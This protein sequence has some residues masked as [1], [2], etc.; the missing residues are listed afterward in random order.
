MEVEGLERI[1]TINH[2]NY[3]EEQLAEKELCLKQLAIIYPNVNRYYAELVYDMCKNTSDEQMEILKKK[4]LEPF[5]Y[6]DRYKNLQEELD[7]QP[8][9]YIEELVVSQ[10]KM[11]ND[12]SGNDVSTNI[13]N[14]NVDI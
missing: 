1:K 8:K 10:S 14:I 4:A 7:N 6:K 2:F 9:I 11:V 12:V 13:E 5:K 3:T